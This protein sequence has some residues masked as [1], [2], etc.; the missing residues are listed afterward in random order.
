MPNITKHLKSKTQRWNTALLIA[1][2]LELNL[3]VLRD[4][5]GD[6]YGITLIA[7]GIVGIILRSVTTGSIDQKE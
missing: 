6:Y 7:V 5:L 3:H 2:F 1:G 4:N